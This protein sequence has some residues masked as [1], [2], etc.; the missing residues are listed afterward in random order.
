M[1]G[2][3]HL[4][5]RRIVRGLGFVG[6]SAALYILIA[7]IFTLPWT[8]YV[9]SFVAPAM[10]IVG[11]LYCLFD[12]RRVARRVERREERAMKTMPA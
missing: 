12:A 4:Y 1:F 9:S 11:L 2:L 10:W 3:G 5:L 6:Y 7:L 8:T